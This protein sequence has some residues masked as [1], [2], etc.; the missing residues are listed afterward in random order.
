MKKFENNTQM[1]V[2]EEKKNYKVE[3]TRK[4]A[5]LSKVAIEQVK[6]DYEN[7]V[8]D[9]IDKAIN[10]EISAEDVKNLISK[11]KE[12]EEVSIKLTS[13]VSGI[14]TNSGELNKTDKEKIKSYYNTGDFTQ[15]ELA[16]IFGTT[17][18]TVSR[19][20]NPDDNDS[21]EE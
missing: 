9:A 10:Q 14:Q 13:I 3:D 7:L 15:K 18:P 11:R 4:K 8:K 12:V 16:D 2:K 17:Q 19:I 20:V 5:V 1:V 6:N 21:D